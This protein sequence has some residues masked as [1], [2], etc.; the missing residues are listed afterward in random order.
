[1]ETEEQQTRPN[2]LRK[3]INLRFCQAVKFLIEN[4]MAHNKNEIMDKLELYLGRLSLILADKG[5]ASTDNLAKLSMCYGVSTEWLLC[6]TGPMLT[7]K[8][9]AP[10]PK[11]R[12]LLSESIPLIPLSALAGFNGIDE[13]GIKL[14][15]CARYYVPEFAQ[16]G[17]DFLI[18]VQG[19][20][21]VPTFVSGDIVACK[22]VETNSW[23]DF[24]ETY[25]IDGAQGIMIKRVF[26][27]PNDPDSFICRSD[28]ES[29]ADFSIAKSEVRSLSKVLGVVRQL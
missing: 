1:M 28:N 10:E 20:S 2:N 7:T 21:M 29:V 26:N 23:F 15:D 5:N 25:V 3:E 14:E 18:R 11:R 8:N 12:D 13:P 9:N 24:G 19:S 22:K 4:K 16:L 6:G 17:A 27:N